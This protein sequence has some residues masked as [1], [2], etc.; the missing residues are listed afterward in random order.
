MVNALT[1]ALFVVLVSALA[2][3]ARPRQPHWV[4]RDGQRFIAMA[5][6]LDNGSGRPGRWTRVHGRIVDDRVRLRQSFL[7]ASVM[8]GTYMVCVREESTDPRIA[9]FTLGEREQ[10]HVKCPSRS[11]L[12]TTLQSMLP[13]A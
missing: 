10:V 3:W 5:C 11:P 9:I 13:R 12:A 4:S 8:A 1:S 6:T 2:L 7:S